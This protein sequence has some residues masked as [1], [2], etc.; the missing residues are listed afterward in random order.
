MKIIGYIHICQKGEWKKSF[1]MLID[2][3]KKSGL[4]EHTTTIRLGILSDE[5]FTEDPILND[6]K[7]QIVYTGNSEEY[8]RPT[9]L[10][11]HTMAVNEDSDNTVYYYLHT[12]GIRHFGMESEQCVIDWISLMLYW[13]IEKWSEAINKLETYDTYGCNHSGNHY[14]GN[15]WWATKKHIANLPST[16]GPEYC[17]PELWIHTKECEIYNA[18]S[19]GLEG[20]GHY[21]HKFPRILY[22]DKLE[23]IKNSLTIHYGLPDNQIEVTTKCFV[24]LFVENMIIIPHNDYTR[25]HIFSDPAIEILKK[26]FIKLD[27]KLYEYDDDCIIVINVCSKTINTIQC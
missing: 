2:S 1:E 13:N 26:V 7:F 3:I 4:Y 12:K 14:S 25:A 22:D 6:P 20:Y 10:N 16:I 23:H 21:S 15:F 9:L 24:D 11:M 5:Q 19:S 17:D 27:D 8:E 18:Y